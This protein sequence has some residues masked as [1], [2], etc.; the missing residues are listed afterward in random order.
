[1]LFLS[2]LLIQ[3][4]R[5]DMILFSFSMVRSELMVLE[6][7]RD[8]ARR[9]LKDLE[10]GIGTARRNP[11]EDGASGRLAQIGLSAEEV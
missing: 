9:E 2:F 8:Q 4:G 5:N 11:P 7:Q 6:Y 3:R 1:M 10:E